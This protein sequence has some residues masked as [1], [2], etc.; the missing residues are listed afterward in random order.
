M[1]EVEAAHCLAFDCEGGTLF[2][3]FGRGLVRAFRVDRPGRWAGGRAGWGGQGWGECSKRHSW[4]WHACKLPVP[5]R[6]LG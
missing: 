1:D 2:C 6:Q 5:K 4:G 3:G